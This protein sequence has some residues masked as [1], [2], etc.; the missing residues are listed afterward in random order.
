MYNPFDSNSTSTFRTHVHLY[1]IIYIYYVYIIP[2]LAAVVRLKR[3]IIEKGFNY[4]LWKS[5][6]IYIFGIDN[7][8]VAIAG[9]YISWPL[10]IGVRIVLMHKT[11]KYIGT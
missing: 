4:V 6:I 2:C 3:S 9:A 8:Q 7:T 10:K 11:R 5:I 1:N